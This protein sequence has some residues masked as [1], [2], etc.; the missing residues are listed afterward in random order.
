[1]RRQRAPMFA[2]IATALILAL[3]LT[4]CTDTTVVTLPG[5][6]G[7]GQ[8]FADAVFGD[9]LT[10]D[11][12]TWNVE[13]FPK[14]GTRT[15]DYLT[16]ALGHL[17]P[18]IVALQEIDGP[19][20]FQH[21]LDQLPDDGGYR[22]TSAPYEQNLAYIYDTRTVQVDTIYEILGDEYRAL[23]RTPLV[24]ECRW[25]DRSLILVDNHFKCCGDG[26]LDLADSRDEETRRYHASLLLHTWIDDHWPDRAVILL[27]DLN[28]SLTD[29][30]S[31]NVFQVFLDD[32]QHYRFADMSIATGPRADW[33]YHGQSHIDHILVTD[34]LFSALDAPGSQVLTLRLDQDLPGGFGEYDSNLSDHL[35]VGLRL[36]F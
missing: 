2:G 28:D 13:N 14:N 20:S 25:R 30:A 8:L 24:L 34:E 36:A 16:A 17:H 3:W 19:T 5:G 12:M 21:V 22:A 31:D 35:P 1:M 6:G 18:D 29:P 9:S 27:G 7:E 4:G 26:R 33:S 10:C 11:V 32:P 23:P 15:V